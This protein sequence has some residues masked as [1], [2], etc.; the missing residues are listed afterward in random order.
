MSAPKLAVNISYLFTELPLI[1]RFS[2]ACDAGFQAIDLSNIAS[3]PLA[4]ILTGMRRSGLPVLQTT[5]AVGSFER[6]GPGV[7]ALP[8]REDEFRAGCQAVL[9]YI[10]ATGL[11]WVHLPS[12]TPGPDMPFEHCYAT[13]LA[14]LR[15][16]IELFA[17]RGVGV[18]IEPINTTDLPGYFLGDLAR[19]RRVVAEFGHDDSLLLLLFDVYHLAMMGLHPIEAFRDSRNDIGHVQFADAPGRHE[20]GTGTID[21]AALLD[22][23]ADTGYAGWFSAEYLPSGDTAAGLGWAKELLK[24]Q[25]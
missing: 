14:N 1:D 18:L 24:P 5:A 15:A 13:Y 11:R 8:G 3:F 2:A 21:F 22:A 4:D 9:P 25:D 6:Q 10:E 20:P 12:G 17:G 23:A 19:A 7:A 16:T